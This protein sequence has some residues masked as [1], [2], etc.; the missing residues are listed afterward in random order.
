MAMPSINAAQDGRHPRAMQ[1]SLA[2]HRLITGRVSLT[3]IL[4]NKELAY[5]L[6][7]ILSSQS[8]GYDWC[9]MSAHGEFPDKPH[10]K[11]KERSSELNWRGF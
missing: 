10:Q 11:L 7:I 8:A 2:S 5:Y 4:E 3:D 1:N 6:I 9:A